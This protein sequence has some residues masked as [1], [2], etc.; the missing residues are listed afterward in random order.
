MT[1]QK[2]FSISTSSN[3][4]TTPPAAAAGLVFDVSQLGSLNCNNDYLVI[5]GGFNVANPPAVINMAFDRYC[6]ERFNALPGNGNSTTV[7]SKLFQFYSQ[8]SLGLLFSF[9]FVLKL[10][11]R[12]SGYST[13]QIATR[14]WLHRQLMRLL[15]K[16]RP[17]ETVDS[18]WIS[19]F[20]NEIDFT[21]VNFLLV[22]VSYSIFWANIA[23][24]S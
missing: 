11:R 7:C 21:V 1:T 17:T 10:L 5:P 9:C 3:Q 20:K 14:R 24:T 13:A 6:G 23:G 4:A 8:I 18:V 22:E 12:P 2:P 16:F 19:K 15:V